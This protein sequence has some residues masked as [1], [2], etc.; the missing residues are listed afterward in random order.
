MGIQGIMRI[1]G[2]SWESREFLRIHRI[3]WADSHI[4]ESRTDFYQLQTPRSGDPPI[5]FESN[6][7]VQYKQSTSHRLEM[8]LIIFIAG[9]CW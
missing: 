4:L 3:Q 1:Q 7:L 9:F 8:H 5:H 2:I 6:D